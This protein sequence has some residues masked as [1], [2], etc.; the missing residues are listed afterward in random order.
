MA[1]RYD[2]LI[3]A[4]TSELSFAF[5]TEPSY[6]YGQGR[7][8]YSAPFTPGADNLPLTADEAIHL[9]L[10]QRAEVSISS[11]VGPT[12]IESLVDLHRSS[13]LLEDHEEA[14]CIWAEANGSEVEYHVRAFLGR[15]NFSIVTQALLA[16]FARKAE[17]LISAGFLGMQGPNLIGDHFPS[18]DQFQMGHPYLYHQKFNFAVTSVS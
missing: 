7:L 1:T 8:L 5:G 17:L 6:W 15:S 18:L 16:T 13:G 4:T 14:L 2:L 9:Q 10:H 3:G 12:G 11:V